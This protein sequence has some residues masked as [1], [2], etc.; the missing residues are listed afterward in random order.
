MEKKDERKRQNTITGNANQQAS[1][2]R[3]L[4]TFTR[5]FG[6]EDKGVM[7]NDRDGIILHI[8]LSKYIKEDDDV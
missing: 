1:R 2:L 3:D 4:S 5:I 8:F 6:D 7:H